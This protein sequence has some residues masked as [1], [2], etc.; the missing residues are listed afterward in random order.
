MA[1]NT[2]ILALF[3]QVDIVFDGKRRSG[4]NNVGG[5]HSM[6]WDRVV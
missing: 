4:R 3:C 5:G 6:G 1:Q 2:A